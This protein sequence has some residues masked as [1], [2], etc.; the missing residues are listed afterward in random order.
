MTDIKIGDTVYHTASPD[1][2]G[3]VTE[4]S[5]NEFRDTTVRWLPPYQAIGTSEHPL[6][7]LR[8]VAHRQARTHQEH[9]IT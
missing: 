6:I 2:H 5:H 7:N 3:I 4:F 1:K 9:N 8:L